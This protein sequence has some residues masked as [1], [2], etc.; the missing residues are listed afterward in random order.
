MCP[1]LG[2]EVPGCQW[3]APAPWPRTGAQTHSWAW[4]LSQP[5]SCC[6]LQGPGGQDDMGQPQGKG[7]ACSGWAPTL[8]KAWLCV[9][10]SAPPSIPGRQAWWSSSKMWA[11]SSVSCLAKKVP[12]S[13]G[14]PSPP[15]HT[16]SLPPRLLSEEPWQ[17]RF[18]GTYVRGVIARWLQ[19]TG[20]FPFFF[21]FKHS[22][23]FKVL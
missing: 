5:F 13:R 1:R 15:R 8:E 22:L 20:V 12:D 10:P 17:G 16:L 6:H 14:H 9:P 21:F 23:F 2:S 3:P 18:P 19:I 4:F 11:G 7:C